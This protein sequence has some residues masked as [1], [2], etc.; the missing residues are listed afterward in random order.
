MKIKKLI[1]EN[2]PPDAP[3][4]STYG[5]YLF[6]PIRRDIPDDEKEEMTPEEAELLSGLQTWINNQNPSDLSAKFPKA[7]KLAQSGKYSKFLIPED[8]PIY[9]GMS[10][11]DDAILDFL[12]STGLSKEDLKV[13][14]DRMFVFENGTLQSPPSTKIMSWSL[15]TEIASVFTSDEDDILVA[16]K[17]RPTKKNGMF[18]LNPKR[19]LQK[20]DF[21]M[22]YDEQ[23]VISYGPV[24]YEKMVVFMNT[25]R[26]MP[27]KEWREIYSR[28]ELNLK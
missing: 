13:K 10:F 1:F 7:Y 28:L 15:S 4:G 24:Q 8:K 18:L 27:A 12:K 6:D 11:S 5:K 20:M 19:I 16:F 26:T 22:L 14:N 17:A 21:P 3:D 2:V 25:D 23:E 9:R